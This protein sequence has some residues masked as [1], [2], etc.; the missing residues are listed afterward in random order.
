[1]DDQSDLTLA[2]T[3]L[4]NIATSLPSLDCNREFSF[5]IWA[6]HA[7]EYRVPSDLKKLTSLYKRMEKEKKLTF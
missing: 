3:L 2:G 1:M 4:T 6:I 7:V 5:P